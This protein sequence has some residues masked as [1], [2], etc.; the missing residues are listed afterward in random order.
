MLVYYLIVDRKIIL[1]IFK[2]PWGFVLAAI[3][4]AANYTGYSIG[5]S[6]TS[7][8]NAQVFIQM[9]PVL[10][11][12][13]GIL[14]FK[15]K[16]SLRQGM[17][18]LVA[19]VGFYLFYTDQNENPVVVNKDY[20]QGVLWILFGA[21]SWATYAVMQK[22]LASKYHPQ[23]LNL[24]I[25]GF[26]T[27]IFLPVADVR[28]VTE[29]SLNYKWLV[30][31]LG[32]NTFAAYGGMAL[33]LKYAEANKVSV[34]FTINPLITFIVMQVLGSFEV[35]WIDQENISSTGLI[36]GAF[37]LVGAAMVILKRHQ[38]K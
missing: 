32:F 17:G 28:S 14:I 37:V 38:K 26:A 5:I 6:Y 11:A 18:F 15:E 31:F 7:P 34:V 30:L 13:S 27:L 36:G 10:L 33:A 35:T 4:L 23:Q 9:G 8:S 20:F 19:V 25:F 2:P 3:G 21:L 29:L 24:F 16:I 1:S 12:I 22:K